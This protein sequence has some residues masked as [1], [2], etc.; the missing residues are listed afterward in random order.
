MPEQIRI[1]AVLETCD[2]EIELLQKQLEALREQKRGLMQKLLTGE[3]RVKVK[4]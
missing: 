3:V 4:G 2:R 1:A